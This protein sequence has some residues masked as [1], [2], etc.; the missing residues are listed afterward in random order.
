MIHVNRA[1]TE[2]DGSGY[3]KVRVFIIKFKR[4]RHVSFCSSSSLQPQWGCMLCNM[5]VG[6]SC[7]L[8]EKKLDAMDAF[9]ASIVG[10][11]FDISSATPLTKR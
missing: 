3:R 6:D 2:F 11:V 8:L 10:Y 5:K 7:Q 9:E 1:T 4:K